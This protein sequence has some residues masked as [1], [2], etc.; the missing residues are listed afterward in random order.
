MFIKLLVIGLSIGGVYSLIGIGYSL[1]YKSSGQMSFV[2]GDLLTLGAFFG[3]TFYKLLSLPFWVSLML[4]L[5]VAFA[6]GFLI[7]RGI[8]RQLTRKKVS[9]IY[10][11]LSTIALS[12]IIQSGAQAAWG[13]ITLYY[14]SVFKTATLTILGAQIM[15]EYVLCFVV[16]L[17]CMVLLHF[18][19]NKTPIG[20]NMR[21]ASMDPLAAESCGID[22]SFM[23]GLSWAIAAGLS[24]VGGMLVGPM[25][26]VY[27]TLGG[28]ISK[29]GFAGAVMGGYGNVY[30]TM[31]G[32]L[33]LGVIETIMA[34]YVSSSYKNMISYIILLLFLFVRPTGIF[35]EK[36]I[37]DV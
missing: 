26:G 22:V 34:S 10:L 37:Q 33:L 31:V 20:T 1:L 19:L 4:T 17:I 35:N 12:Y 18:F 23:T 21:A 16:S 13:S 3:Y 15:P 25:Y 11:I 24:A 8:I 9:G 30:G 7:E 27:T 2:Q 6:F 32:G 5:C 36:A 29:K 28:A 14:P